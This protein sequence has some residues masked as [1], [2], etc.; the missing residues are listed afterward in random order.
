MSDDALEPYPQDRPRAATVRSQ[1]M[2]EVASDMVSRAEFEPKQGRVKL[3]RPGN[4]DWEIDLFASDGLSAIDELVARTTDIAILNPACLAA[5]ALGGF[6][7][8]E[9]PAPLRAIATIP[10]H[11]QL[12]VAVSRRVG[13]SSLPELMG[14]GGLRYSLRGGRRDHS[15]HMLVDDLLATLGS[16][17]ADLGNQGNRIGYDEGIPHQPPRVEAILAGEVDVVIDEGIYNWVDLASQAGFEFLPIPEALLADLEGLGYR[18]DTIRADRYE[19]LANDIAT[20]GFS[21]F[22]ILTHAAVDDELVARFCESMYARRDRIRWQ[23]GD[24]LPFARM[25]GDTVDA[26]LPIP[27]HP[28]AERQ[29]RSLGLLD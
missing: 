14:M 1:L 26:P 24:K 2:L 25:L 23:G 19:T 10:S 22:L 3:R 13:A 12:G 27:F 4:P 8:F 15:I 28:G 7:P 17:L 21:G 29:W 5:K 11:D 16:S 9:S 6:P 20:V 18:R